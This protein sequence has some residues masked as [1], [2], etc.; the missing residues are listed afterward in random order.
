MRSIFMP[1]KGSTEKRIHET[2]MQ[3]AEAQ[4]QVLPRSWYSPGMD[5]VGEGG[6]VGAPP[7]PP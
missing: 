1:P 2:T 7:P 5:I 3:E 4:G 6:G